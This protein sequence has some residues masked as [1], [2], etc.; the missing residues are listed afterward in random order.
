MIFQKLVNYLSIRDS[1]SFSIYRIYIII[2]NRVEKRRKEERFL[3]SD[4][5]FK[6]TLGSKDE[7]TPWNTKPNDLSD[8][9]MNL[10][11]FF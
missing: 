11:I 10:M 4:S 7:S 8:Y 1:N 5:T 9:L 3:C 6:R 2:E